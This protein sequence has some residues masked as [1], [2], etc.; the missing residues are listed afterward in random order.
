MQSTPFPPTNQRHSMVEVL[1]PAGE[2]GDALASPSAPQ[3]PTNH[4]RFFNSALASAFSSPVGT[5]YPAG[6]SL[7]QVS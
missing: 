6:R 3:V 5:T 4:A 2:N 7:F 1:L